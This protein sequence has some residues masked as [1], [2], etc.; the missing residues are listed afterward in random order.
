MLSTDTTWL[1]YIEDRSA[2]RQIVLNLETENLWHDMKRCSCILLPLHRPRFKITRAQTRE[3]SSFLEHSWIFIFQNFS[4][5]VVGPLEAGLVK[6]N[7][8]CLLYVTIPNMHTM[9]KQNIHTIP[10]CIST[11]SHWALCSAAGNEWSCEQ[12]CIV[13]MA[14]TGQEAQCFNPTGMAKPSLCDA[15]WNGKAFLESQYKY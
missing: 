6:T 13:D 5:Q 11:Q 8:K 12:M 2:M 3:N 4:T 9:W 15:K 14:Q 10:L 1:N 7:E